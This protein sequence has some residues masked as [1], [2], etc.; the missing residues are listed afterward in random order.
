M[1]NKLASE[2]HLRCPSELVSGVGSHCQ[3][4]SDVIHSCID[5]NVIRAR[6]QTFIDERFGERGNTRHT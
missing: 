5:D 2:G 6:I 3:Q 1:S 4:L